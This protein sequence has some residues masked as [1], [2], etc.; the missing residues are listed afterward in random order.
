VTDAPDAPLALDFRRLGDGAWATFVYGSSRPLVLRTA[1]AMARANDL[2]PVWIEIEE[3]GSHPEPDGP[4]GLGWVPD[5]QRFRL[6][7]SEAMPQDGVANIALWTVV[8]ADEPDSAIA[9]FTDF[10]RL[11][12]IV[13]EAVSRIGSESQRPVFVIA[14]TDRVRPYYPRDVP[15]VRR[16]VDALLSAGV[17]PIFAAVGPPGPGRKA[18]DFVFELRGE[19][20]TAAHAGSLVCEQAPEASGIPLDSPFAFGSISQLAGYLSP[21]V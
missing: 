12:T 21:Q 16:V 4:I 13:Q 14:N 10:L 6:S 9:Q 1:Y 20:S 5:E 18:F 11:P 15:G 7:S 19:E 17:L 2:A 3:S 8:R